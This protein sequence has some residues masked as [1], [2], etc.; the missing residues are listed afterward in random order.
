MRPK[1]F[2]RRCSAFS[3][4]GLRDLHRHASAIP[5]SLR[6]SATEAVYLVARRSTVPRS[7]RHGQFANGSAFRHDND[8]I[9]KRQHLGRS[10]DT[11]SRATP[12]S[13]SARKS[14]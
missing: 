8:A 10:E 2:S 9:G 5:A 1:R 4:I 14:R 11:T 12:L 6:T 13:A 7:P 3:A